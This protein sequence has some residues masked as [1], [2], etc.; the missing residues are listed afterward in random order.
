MRTQE[1][2]AK[3]LKWSSENGCELYVV[4]KLGGYEWWMISEKTGT[5]MV[6]NKGKYGQAY[7]CDR[8]LAHWDGF[9]KNQNR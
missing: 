3:G 6:P 9:K 2:K 4:V 1:I 5:H 7:A 8:V